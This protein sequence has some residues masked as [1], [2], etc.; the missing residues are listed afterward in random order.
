MPSVGKFLHASAYEKHNIHSL[1]NALEQ[2]KLGIIIAY[3]DAYLVTGPSDGPQTFGANAWLVTIYFR[4]VHLVC[5]ARL[6][7]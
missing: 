6:M 7:R 5:E 4:P 3:I 2:F 1:F